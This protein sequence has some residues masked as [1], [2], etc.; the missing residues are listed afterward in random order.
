M[1]DNDEN[2][3]EEVM[4]VPIVV[5]LAGIVTDVNPVHPEKA[6]IPSVKVMINR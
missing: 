1:T 3:I 4:M 5:T 6:T 2:D